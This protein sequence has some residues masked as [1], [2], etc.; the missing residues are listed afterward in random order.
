M[1]NLAATKSGTRKLS[2]VARELVL[3]AGIAFSGWPDISKQ[4]LALGIRFEAWQD[5]IGRA[6]FAKRKDG[7]YA[8]S[9][10]G[11]VM[12]IPRQVGKTYFV[13]G[14]AFA[15]C[16]LTPGSKVIWT[17]H[18]SNTA[19]E[20]FEAMSAMAQ[21]LKVSPHVRAVRS[22]NGQQRIIFR[23]RSRIE[24]G[25]RERGFGRGKQKVSLLVLDEAQILTDSALENMVPSMNRATNP[26]MFMM[27]TP[28][29]P[30][31]PGEM[32][33]NKRA[34]ALDKTSKNAV[35]IELAADSDADPDDRAQ[36]A[37]ANPSYPHFTPEEAML[38]MREIFTDDGFKREA[39]GIWDAVGDSRVIDAAVW[40][41]QGDRASMAI[42]RR[43]LAIDVSMDRKFATVSLAG[44]R[45]DGNW[46]VELF[47]ERDDI[48]GVDWV[49]PW[50]KTLTEKKSALHAVVIDEMSGLVEK[51]NGRHFLIGTDI[52]VT[53]AGASGRDMAI[54]CAKFY[55]GITDGSVFHTDQAPVNVALSVATK[56]PLQGGWAWNRKDSTSNISPMV[57]QT[58]A[59]WGAQ[60][61]NVTRPTRRTTSS[62][63]AVVL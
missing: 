1:P 11:V 33:T 41:A 21:Q 22:T 29:R 63:T 24:F 57:S 42:D 5:G 59:L 55:D 20:T 35:Y 51:R 39:L 8:A 44:L 45:A 34:R 30:Q 3:P 10:G 62:R 37:K 46:H 12:S 6:A 40:E 32:F 28:P 27:G 15:V 16:L 58:L 61:D 31:D 14:V 56:R 26:L 9:V 49:I 17:A 2:E 4:C 38:R 60:N 7:V 48:R 19:D 52:A 43:T 13:G 18:H 54:A 36:W 23:N 25:A 53:L 47:Q 50:V